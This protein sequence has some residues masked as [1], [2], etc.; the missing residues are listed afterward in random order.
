[1]NGRASDALALVGEM[2]PVKPNS[3]TLLAVLAA[4]A[5][6]GL[7]REGVAYLERLLAPECSAHA[8]EPRLVCTVA[9]LLAR[10]GYVESAAMIAGAAGGSAVAWSAVLSGC[11]T[12]N[13]IGDEAGQNAARHV[14]ELEPD[15]SAGYLM[16]SVVDNGAMRRM[17]R[18]RGVQVVAG[19]SV[20]H[21]AGQEHRFS[22]W[23]RRHPQRVQIYAMLHLLHC[24]MTWKP[25]PP[26]EGVA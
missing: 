3:V 17:M 1:M 4:C 14:L 7:V 9:D 6:G 13:W 26:H 19:Y 24:H 2:E 10:G 23:D 11:R 15:N 5:H 12:R 16:A 18:A 22:S 21:V 25:P 20:A 8:E